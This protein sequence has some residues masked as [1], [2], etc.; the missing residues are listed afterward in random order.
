M[1]ISDNKKIE[2]CVIT[3]GGTIEKSYDE[4]TG[5]LVNRESVVKGLLLAHLRLPYTELKMFSL[6]SKD[7]LVMTDED[8]ELLCKFVQS[9]GKEGRPILIIHGTDTM[10]KTALYL[11]EHL[12]DIE[13]P[14]VFTGAMKP[15]GFH[16]SDAPQNVTE[17]LVALKLLG[18]GVFISF[19]NRVF[20][21]PGVRKNLEKLTFEYYRP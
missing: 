3:T 1:I 12:N 9:K 20:K 13:V 2:V 11:H 14:V 19:H 4:H 15:I 6:F 18:P 5:H 17:A 10:E 16:D 7:S 21:L 8:R